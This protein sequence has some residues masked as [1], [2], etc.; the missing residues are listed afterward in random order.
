MVQPMV[1]V[2]QCGWSKTKIIS[3]AKSMV[4]A[5]FQDTLVTK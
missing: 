2:D 3:L 4:V 5:G 1:L